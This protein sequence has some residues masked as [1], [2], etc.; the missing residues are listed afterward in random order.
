MASLATR[1]LAPVVLAVFLPTVGLGDSGEALF[2]QGRRAER[3]GRHIEAYLLYNRA[4]ALQPG[5]LTFLRAARRVRRGAAQLM[6]AS[7]EHHAAIQMAPDSWEFE[8]LSEEVPP[9]TD[10]SASIIAR[11]HRVPRQPAR[12]SFR[13]HR[14]SFR[15]RSTVLEAYEA[16]AREFGVRVRLHD[17]VDG[18][19]P[20]RATL[21]DCDLRCATRAIGA[22]SKSVALV[23]A[24]DLLFVV[25]D[26][27]SARAEFETAAVSSIPFDSSLGVEDV[28]QLGQAIQQVLDIRRLS[29]TPS[30]GAL[31][32]RGPVSRVDMAHALASDLLRPQGAVQIEI[33]MVTAS[34]SSQVRGGIDLPSSFPVV[35]FSTLFGGIPGAGGVE[36]LVG[37]GGGKTVLGVAVGDAN[38][39]ARLNTSTSESI[40]T[41]RLRGVHGTPAEFK[42]G[43]S[44]PIMTAQ[45]LSDQG[46]LLGTPG[47]VQPPPSVTFQDLGLNLTVTPLIHNAYEVTLL[48]EVAFK[49]L[50]GAAVNDIP[51][52]ANREFQSRVRLKRSEFAI[53]SG[54]AIFERRRLAG[55]L[56][57]GLGT[58]PVLGSLFGRNERTWS[59][60]E[61]LILVRPRI[62]RLPAG[63][64]A[65][66]KEF[67]FG[68]EERALPAL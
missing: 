3:Q 29:V 30:A 17:D 53:V 51:V 5:N 32:L 27:E 35:N 24:P 67:L 13:D 36:R 42:V 64:L 49:F 44:F 46:S 56:L 18:D 55:G 7:G 16:V 1:I 50:S 45:Y 4:R 54:T 43:E 39:E 2:Q 10:G 8:R 59:Q 62:L 28:T 37:F 14:A 11:G 48:L 19:R 65:R 63:E 58:I 20:I 52:L 34:R 57:A 60:R 31:F 6:A 38:A 22:L 40:H 47:Y 41:M 21:S 12:L 25:E 9:A 23:V 61:L 26:N 33:E 15:F 68:T 66:S